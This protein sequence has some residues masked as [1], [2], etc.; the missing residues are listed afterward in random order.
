MHL[1]LSI[2]TI[3]N[4]DPDNNNN[5]E[6]TSNRETEPNIEEQINEGL[7]EETTSNTNCNR[8][9]SYSLTDFNQSIKCNSFQNNACINKEISCKIKVKHSLIQIIRGWS[10][11]NSY[12]ST[13]VYNL[14][15]QSCQE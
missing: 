5:N 13:S 12:Y 14:S 11:L 4:E 9:I 2:Y 8:K 15:N 10:G 7:E 1:I 3:K 6:E